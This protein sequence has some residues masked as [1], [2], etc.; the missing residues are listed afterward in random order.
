M[1]QA[2]KAKLGD[3]RTQAEKIKKQRTPNITYVKFLRK[4]KTSHSRPLWASL[5]KE[6]HICHSCKKTKN[7][8]G[9]QQ[10]NKKRGGIEKP[11]E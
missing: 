3:S 6:R 8:I 9:D 10:P 7:N 2:C 1:G 4:A 5:F 11:N